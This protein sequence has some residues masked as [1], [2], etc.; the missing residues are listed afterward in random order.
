MP[1]HAEPHMTRG[2]VQ[3][4]QQQRQQPVGSWAAQQA[5]V[6]SPGAVGAARQAGESCCP[7]QPGA[8]RMMSMVL[9]DMSA[10]WLAVA[11]ALS[12]GHDGNDAGADADADDVIARACKV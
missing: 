7:S 4:Q 10:M 12:D 3:H 2:A 11:S 1:T 5:S 9:A 8:E 6:T